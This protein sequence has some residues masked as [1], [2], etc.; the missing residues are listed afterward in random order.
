MVSEIYS[1][2]FGRRWCLMSRLAYTAGLILLISATYLWSSV[3]G[4]ISGIVRDPSGA[5]VPE[6]N[7]TATETET[8]IRHSTITDTNGFYVFPSMVIGHYSIKIQKMGFETSN[9]SGLEIN[10]NSALRVDA[11]LKLGQQLQVVNISASAL[12]VETTSTQM[13]EVIQGQKMVTLPLNGR[14]YTDL[15][16]LQPGVV[17]VGAPVESQAYAVSGNLNPGT[18]SIGGQRQ[19]ANAFMVNGADVEEGRYNGAGIIPNLDSFAEFRILTNSYDAE[20]GNYSGGQINVVTKSGANQLHGNVFEFLRNG[21]MDSRNFFS[22]TRGVLRQ[23][24]FGGTVGGPI[25]HNQAFFFG[26]YQGTR[27][28]VG[29]DTGLIRVPSVQDRQGSLGD[30][31]SRLTGSVRG[32]YYASLLSQALGY[33]VTQG[34]P[35]YTN[36]CTS[37]AQCVFPNAVIPQSIWAAPASP[38]MQYIPEPNSGGTFF[39]T[40]AFNQVL[41]DDKGAIRV[42]GNSRLGMLSAY[43]YIDDYTLDN[44]Y[45]YANVPGFNALTSGRGQLWVLN[46]TKSFGPSVVNEIV[47]SYMRDTNGFGVPVGGVG[48]S[49][50]SL[51]FVVGEGTLGIVPQAPAYEGV[52]PIGFSSY[53]IG[54]PPRLELQFNNTYQVQDNYS[55]VVGTHVLKLGAN[56]HYDQ[57]NTILHAS[58]NGKFSF[59]GS[60]TGYDFADF[61]IGAPKGYTQSVEEGTYHRTKYLGLYVQDGWRTTSNLTLNYGLRWEVSMPWYEEHNLVNAIVPG[62]QSK[63]FLGAPTGWVFP[64]DPGIPSTVAPTRYNNFAPRIGLAYSPNANEGLLRKLS[65]GTGKMSIRAGF[66]IFYTAVQDQTLIGQLADAPYGNFYSSPAPPVFTTP[67]IDR[68][69]GNIQGQR[70]PVVFPPLDVSAS[71]P[72]NSVDWT[73]L[74]PISGSPAYFHQNRLPYSVQ[75]NLSIQRQFG[76]NTVLSLDYVGSQGHRLIAFLAANPGNADLCLSLS[77]PSQVMPGTSTCGPNGEDTTYTSSSGV[78]VEGTRP[79]GLDFSTV[80]WNANMANSNYNSLQ[81]AVRHRSGS[82]E[83]LVGYTYSKC[84]TNASGFESSINPFNQ[85]LSKALCLFDLTHNFVASYGYEIPFWRVVNNRNRLTEGWVLSGITHIATGLPV[86][87]SETDDRSLLGYNSGAGA[88]DTPNVAPGR[89]LNNTDPR[90]RQPYFNTSLFSFETLGQVGTANP[91]FFHGPGIINFDL[92]LLKNLKLT[93]SKFLQLRLE[94]FNAFNHASFMNPTGNINSGTFGL[95]TNARAPRILQVGA[96]I[97]F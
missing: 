49:L 25:K 51:G 14:S 20:Y 58:S 63:V 9:T 85:R 32:P 93:E 97:N 66:G 92:A 80:M 61:L 36:G 28:V 45:P 69:T 50:G 2:E 46:D 26:D 89:I 82:A 19:A 39:T 81:T 88:V 5:V 23:N 65:G 16:A 33:N 54:M 29:V 1:Q 62:L 6:A 94:A 78:V 87:L 73:K 96:K 17:P 42:D 22:P 35:Y 7:V 60:E 37:S 30:I 12:H 77:Q 59:N 40:S 95:V 15:L 76:N 91:S 34:E 3:G 57:V 71:N 48:V 31:A 38:L 47:L 56:F 44:P 72:D 11:V 67:F 90:S 55:K 41:R 13:G 83:F 8:G 27:N 53:S 52:P 84:M 70:F 75:Y 21:A 10:A 18:L 43:Y 86:P 64:G 4:S 24:Q 74:L 68:G 79:L